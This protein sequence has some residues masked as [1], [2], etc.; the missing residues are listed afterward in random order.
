MTDEIANTSM[1]NPAVQ[2]YSSKLAAWEDV[3]SVFNQP[4]ICTLVPSSVKSPPDLT[5]A[6]VG[7]QMVS[8]LDESKA[9]SDFQRAINVLNPKP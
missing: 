5:H 9:S 3:Y 2:A 6:V 1:T 7:H 8:R 4:E